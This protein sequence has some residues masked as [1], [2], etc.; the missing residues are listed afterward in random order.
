MN[1][2]ENLRYAESHEWILVDGDTG[3]VGITDHAR[4]N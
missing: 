1:V 3:L 4:P 2:P